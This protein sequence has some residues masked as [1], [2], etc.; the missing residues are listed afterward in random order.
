MN[1]RVQLC[2]NLR[3][4]REPLTGQ[5]DLVSRGIRP[6]FFSTIQSDEGEE[7]GGSL[8]CSLKQGTW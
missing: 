4:R 8:E 2:K 3:W 7:I 6:H 1:I 5:S